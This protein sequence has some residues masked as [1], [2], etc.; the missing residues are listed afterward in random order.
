MGH[1]GKFQTYPVFSPIR[2]FVWVSQMSQ[3]R[4]EEDDPTSDAP[5]SAC[6]DIMSYAHVANKAQGVWY[7]QHLYP[8]V[9]A[10]FEGQLYRLGTQ[11]GRLQNYGPF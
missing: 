11:V 9:S 5:D 10:S 8:S 4:A 6:E 7:D 1:R 2:S 3:K